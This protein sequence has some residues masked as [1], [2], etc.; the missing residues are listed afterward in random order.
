MTVM[1][2]ATWKISGN[3]GRVDVEVN[4]DDISGQVRRV[5]VLLDRDRIPSLQ[6]E[7]EGAGT[8]EGTGIVKVILDDEQAEVPLGQA[9]LRFI[10]SVDPVELEQQIMQGGMGDGVAT[11]CLRALRGMALS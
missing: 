2:L 6:L 9:V 5:A 4:G 11:A 10:E 1:D 7:L 8:L 3:V